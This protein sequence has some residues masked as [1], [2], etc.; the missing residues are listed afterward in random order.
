MCLHV[1][2]L[3]H[4][5]RTKSAWWLRRPF[6]ESR[7]C[8]LFSFSMLASQRVDFSCLQSFQWESR[9]RQTV[10]CSSLAQI[11]LA[12]TL[13][14]VLFNRQTVR[15]KTSTLKNILVW[16]MRRD[17]EGFHQ[18]TSDASFSAV[19]TVGSKSRALLSRPNNSA[20]RSAPYRSPYLWI[21]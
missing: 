17:K 12:C 4:T 18:E 6:L 7:D 2:H 9:R 11:R 19:S 13:T 16:K 8:N 21:T 10:C 14:S 3:F 5:H 1:S 15:Y 20:M